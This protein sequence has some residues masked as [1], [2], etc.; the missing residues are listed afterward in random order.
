MKLRIIITGFINKVKN[1]LIN[2]VIFEEIN[3]VLKMALC[4]GLGLSY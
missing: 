1:E 2:E 4:S 3:V